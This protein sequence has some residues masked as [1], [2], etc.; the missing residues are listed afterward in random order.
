MKIYFATHATSLDNELKIS[1]GWRDVGLSELGQKQA[2]E[3]AHY[4]NNIQIEQIFC[5]DLKRAWE[6]A[7]IAFGDT[8]KITSDERLRELNYGDYNGKPSTIVGPMKKQHIQTP[9]P[10]GESYEQAEKRVHQSLQEIKARYPKQTILIIGH[11][12]T[13]YGLDTFTGKRTLEEGVSEKFVWQPYW[14]YDL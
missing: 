11:R 13:H 7:K 2:K 5:S 4:F 10:N 1:S 9:F 8:H 14:E 6:T 12:A 3:L